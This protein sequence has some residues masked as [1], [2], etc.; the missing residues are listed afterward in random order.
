MTMSY[1]TVGAGGDVQ[2]RVREQGVGGHQAQAPRP[3]LLQQGKI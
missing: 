1:V 3:C 2:Q